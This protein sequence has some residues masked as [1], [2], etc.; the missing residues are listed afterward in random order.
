MKNYKDKMKRE[1]AEQFRAKDHQKNV[2]YK[3]WIP[4]ELNTRNLLT[5]FTDKTDPDA[6]AETAANLAKIAKKHGAQIVRKSRH[7]H[8]EEFW[9][10]KSIKQPVDNSLCFRTQRL[11]TD[12][13]F[14]E[15]LEKEEYWFIEKEAEKI[16][17]SKKVTEKERIKSKL[18]PY[19]RKV[20]GIK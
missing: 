18:T 19:E 2:I 12:F 1:L 8:G 13:E 9:T 11:E 4:E 3:Y 15:R 10:T 6:F 17:L 5:L 20:L 14:E 7:V 16:R